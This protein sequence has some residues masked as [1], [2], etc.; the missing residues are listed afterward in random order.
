M[1]I[2]PL[3]LKKKPLENAIRERNAA[4]LASIESTDTAADD[5]WRAWAQ[6]NLERGVPMERIRHDL[7]ENG[8]YRMGSS[9]RS[10][11]R[12]KGGTAHHPR[13]PRPRLAISRPRPH[14]RSARKPS[15]KAL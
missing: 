6:L 5:Q 13:S 10:P 9:S 1:I 7:K 3:P 2:S 15:A 12:A 4:L 11:P 8:G 14:P